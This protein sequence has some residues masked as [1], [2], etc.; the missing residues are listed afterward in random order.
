LAAG[1]ILPVV[2][3]SGLWFAHWDARDRLAIASAEREARKREWAAVSHELDKTATVRRELEAIR[4]MSAMIADEGAKPR[5][6]P[7]LRC[8]VPPGNTEI[9]ILEI[10]ATEGPEDPGSCELIIRGVAKG[11]QAR[12]VADRFRRTLE[13]SMKRNANGRPVSTH[14]NQIEEVPRTHP[15]Q[16]QATFVVTARFGSMEPTVAMSREDR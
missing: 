5:W 15:E 11:V 14:L 10:Q 1:I 7:A 16:Q 8:I 6:T 13:D 9:D 4:A 12:M 2:L 3:V